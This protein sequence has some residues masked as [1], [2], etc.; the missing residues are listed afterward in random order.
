[1]NNMDDNNKI[2]VNWRS[3]SFRRRLLRLPV[4]LNVREF[5]RTVYLN[6]INILQINI[7]INGI[8]PVQKSRDQAGGEGSR[9]YH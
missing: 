9:K 2:H 6:I 3:F 7:S 5:F 1:M 8:G 4:D